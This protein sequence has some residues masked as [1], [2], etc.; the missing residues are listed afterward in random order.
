[1]DEVSAA[2]VVEKIGKQTTS[3]GIVAHVLNDAASIGIAVSFAE[4]LRS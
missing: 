1:L 4:L 2:H 3:E